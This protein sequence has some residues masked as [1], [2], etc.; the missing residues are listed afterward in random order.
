MDEDEEGT[1]ERLK[2]LLGEVV[3]P[4][5]TLAELQR[6]MTRLGFI[7]SQIGEIEDARQKRLEQQP[8]TGPQRWFGCSP[9]SSGLV[10]RRLICWSTRCCHGQCV[11]AEPLRATPA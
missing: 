9:A 11:T 6:D 5:N 3:V 4:P 10:S 7:V 1:H 8:E 2:A